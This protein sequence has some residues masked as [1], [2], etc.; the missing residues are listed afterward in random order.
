MEQTDA[1]PLIWDYQKYVTIFVIL[2]K[3]KKMHLYRLPTIKILW[4]IDYAIFTAFET[5]KVALNNT[6]VYYRIEEI[7]RYIITQKL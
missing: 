3:G 5:Q 7:C 1:A 2:I 4:S 6:I